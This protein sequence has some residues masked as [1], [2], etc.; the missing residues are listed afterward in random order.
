MTATSFSACC[1]RTCIDWLIDNWL[2]ILYFDLCILLY[3]ILR[4]SCWPAFCQLIIYE[5][6]I[7]LYCIDYEYATFGSLCNFQII[8][9]KS[10]M[11]LRNSLRELV[12][13]YNRFPG[14]LNRQLAAVT[15]T[16]FNRFS[17]VLSAAKIVKLPNKACTIFSEKSESQKKTQNLSVVLELF[18]TLSA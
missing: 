13:N 12:C 11:Q 6:C 8:S 9:T 2:T 1:T 14:K 18:W 15:S 4:L 16:S 10:K 5:Y 17:T 7:V 3:F